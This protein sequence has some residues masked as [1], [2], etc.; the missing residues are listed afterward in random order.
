[1]SRILLFVAW[2]FLRAIFS[3]QGSDT[4]QTALKDGQLSSA[5]AGGERQTWFPK[6][7]AHFTLDELSSDLKTFSSDEL[8][9]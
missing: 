3:V 8:T 9:E 6:E 1:M 2:S 5:A 4:G 7:A